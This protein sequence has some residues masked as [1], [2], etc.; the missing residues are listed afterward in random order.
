VAQFSRCPGRHPRFPW[1]FSSEAGQERRHTGRAAQD[2]CRHNPRAHLA[3]RVGAHHGGRAV[4]P[5]ESSFLGE[6]NSQTV[7]LGYCHALGRCI[8]KPVLSR[9]FAPPYCDPDE[10]T[11]NNLRHSGEANRII[12]R[13][14]ACWVLFADPIAELRGAQRESGLVVRATWEQQ[15]GPHGI[16]DGAPQKTSLCVNGIA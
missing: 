12:N 7:A 15:I 13:A 4:Y 16:G 5:P 10:N 2:P 6:R 8:A 3:R 9:L 14:V 1:E 11:C